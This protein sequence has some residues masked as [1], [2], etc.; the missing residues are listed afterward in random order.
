VESVLDFREKR[1]YI[2]ELPVVCRRLEIEGL[3]APGVLVVRVLPDVPV[4]GDPVEGVDGRDGVE[5]LNLDGAVMRVVL[6]G[7]TVPLERDVEVLGAADGLE[8]VDG[9][10]T[11][12]GRLVP[13]VL[14]E[15]LVP[16]L[17]AEED[18]LLTL[19]G[20]PMLREPMTMRRVV[21]EEVGGLVEGEVGRVD[22]ELIDGLRMLLEDGAR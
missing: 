20:P 12:T 18:R 9:L 15:L 4:L 21:D 10:L 8:E 22:R 5:R 7:L 13:E 11:I 6:D 17:V 2:L 1:V 14:G 3:L 16:D 19:T